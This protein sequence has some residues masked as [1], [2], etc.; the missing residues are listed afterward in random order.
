MYPHTLHTKKVGVNCFTYVWCIFYVCSCSTKLF[1]LVKIFLVYRRK[2]YIITLVTSLENW[3]QKSD[4]KLSHQNHKTVR[5][6]VENNTKSRSWKTGE[7]N[8]V[9]LMKIS[10]III[11]DWTNIFAS[12]ISTWNLNTETQSRVR[13]EFQNLVNF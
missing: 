2:Q 9:C 4:N 11:T 5:K 10:T 7:K 12:R 1:N 3:D 6:L 8:H 13:L